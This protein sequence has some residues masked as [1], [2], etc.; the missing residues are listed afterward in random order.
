[1]EEAD[2]FQAVGFLLEA[3]ADVNRIST[4]SFYDWAVI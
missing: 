1:M 3:G 2:Q 4:A